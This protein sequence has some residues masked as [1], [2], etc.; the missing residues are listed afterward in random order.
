MGHLEPPASAQ[1]PGSNAMQ[2]HSEAPL[3]E[4]EVTYLVDLIR[5]HSGIDYHPGK[6]VALRNAVVQR[7]FQLEIQSKQEFLELIGSLNGKEE[8][9]KLISLVVVQKTS[10]FRDRPQFDLMEKTVL[11]DIASRRKEKSVRVWSAGCAT[12]EEPYS[13]AMLL[14][15]N[16]FTTSQA[17]ILATDIARPSLRAAIDGRYLETE[18]SNLNDNERAM[19]LPG[20]SSWRLSDSIRRMVDFKQHNLVSVPFPV[21]HGDLWDIIFCRNVLIY[22]NRATVTE[23][24]KRFHEVLTPGGFLFLGVSESLFKLAEG[25]E[26]LSAEN[27]FVYR[28]PDPA[29]RKAAAPAK[30]YRR[31]AVKAKARP[32]PSRQSPPPAAE[33]GPPPGPAFSDLEIG[34]RNARRMLAGKH[35]EAAEPYLLLGECALSRGAMWEAWSW[36]QAACE[37]KP[38]DIE[39]H[40]LLAVVLHR[41]GLDQEAFEHLRKLLFLDGNFAL[42]HYYLGEVAHRL[43][44]IE[45]AVRSFR[46]VIRISQ[47]TPSKHA[48]EFLAKHHLSPD[49]L[50]EAS[51]ARLRQIEMRP[52]SGGSSE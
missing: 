9:K 31:P 35:P 7:M 4:R 30:A 34:I 43:G 19:F 25:F 10:F 32:A 13:I 18:L 14:R 52:V 20:T 2:L 33:P 37:I 39:G 45:T 27:A 48:R 26:L 3:T 42:G 12:G 16:S 49:A 5:R 36:Y 29:T 28:K 47:T 17:T 24:I 15:R 23:I 44:D 40:F 38:L 46:N 11:P 8:L 50:I 51:R 6:S 1:Q 21:P 22:F 41:I